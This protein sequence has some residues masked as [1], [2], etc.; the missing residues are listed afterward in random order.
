[1]PQSK[2][3]RNESIRLAVK[4]H[5][6]VNKEKILAKKAKYYIYKKECKRLCAILL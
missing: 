1:M 2:K 4:I 3:E 6:D 5:Y